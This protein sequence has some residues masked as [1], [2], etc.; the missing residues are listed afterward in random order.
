[1]ITSRYRWRVAPPAP[2]GAGFAEAARARGIGEPAAAILASRGVG[3]AIALDAFLGPAEDGLNDPRLLPDAE[4]AVAR[5][6]RAIR[7][8]EGVMVF[9]DF[10][11]DGLTGLAV[12]VR[13]L[14]SLGLDA[15]PYVPS[16]LAEGHGLSVASVER[17]RAEG[18]TLIVTVDCGSSSPDEVDLARAAGIDV[19]VTD[20]HR[21]PERI[22][23]AVAF[24][25]PHRADGTYPDRRLAGAGVA[26]TV[27]RLL[28][29][30]LGGGWDPLALAD[31]AM[32]GT[33]GDVA[34]IL[35]EN[36][37]IARLGLR[38]L[39]E[40]PRPALA[41][42]LSRAGVRPD[43]ADLETVAFQ[44]A[45][46]LNAAGRVGEA[47]EAAG[48]LLTDD[49]ADAES[50]AALLEAANDLRRDLLRS[51]LA[52]ARATLAEGTV[53]EDAPAILLQGPWSPGIVGLVAARLAEEHGR[54][55]V[56]GAR[57]D[58]VV[59][60]SCRAAGRLDLAAALDACGDDLFLRHGGHAGAAGFD[61]P[62]DRWGS[63]CERFAAIA[64]R[65]A[66]TD[67]RPDLVVD[68]AIPTDALD[69]ALVRDL[70]VLEPTGPGNPQPVIAVSDMTVTRVRAATGGHAQITLRRKRDV[71]DAIAF[72]REDLATQL[73][74]GDRVDVAARV[75]VRAYGG[76]DSLQLEV[77]DVAPV[78]TVQPRRPSHGDRTG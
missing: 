43:A 1:V 6:R 12:L 47:E 32:I 17:A 33:V 78:G 16:R 41:A 50:I 46:R 55:A 67:P 42:L 22:P 19:I 13:A 24:V 62:A 4:R 18:R 39:R 2:A 70:R 11:A 49:G 69:H 54:P 52:E 26:F 9:G 73:R 66:P 28:H 20:H 75:G 31:L 36:R 8:G 21:V 44:I 63:F 10:D 71:V 27:A 57:L 3:D 7:D 72:G 74:E 5:I 15:T 23:D 65:T 64:A 25:N 30:E 51:T 58:G 34:P 35:G 45:P 56:I 53:P 37:A 59:R 40:T 29:D 60:A 76:Y 14:R 61:L 38:S 68:L 77:R 48:L